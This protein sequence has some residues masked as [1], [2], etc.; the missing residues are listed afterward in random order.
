M[1]LRTTSV[2]AAVSSAVLG[3]PALS[4]RD[5]AAMSGI[6][7]EQAAR[8]WQ[9]LGF[10]AVADDERLFTRRDVD[11]LRFVHG[12]F[13]KG[14]VDPE[15]LVQMARATGQSLARVANMHVLSAAAEIEA[16]VQSPDLSDSDAA[17]CVAAIA[18]Q[19]VASHEPFLGYIWRRHLLAA[20]SQTAATA[21]QKAGE[22]DGAVVG[23][24]DLVDFTAMSERLSERELAS[25]VDRFEAI[26][27]AEIPDRGG[28]VVKILG[29]EVMFHN[30]DAVAGARTALALS[31]ACAADS[32][33]PEVRVGLAL[34]PILAWEGDVYGKTVNLASRLVGAA[35]P[36]T[37]LVSEELALRITSAPDLIVR[38]IRP[39]K[40]KG[41]GRTRC[42]VLRGA[43]DRPQDD[44]RARR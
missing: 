8:L 32:V 20:I 39:V 40:L 28:R 42:W 3:K 4:A 21:S 25:I 12:M 16:A 44:A 13:E 2:R 36:G 17:D 26:A 1:T 22:E 34:G 31:Q 35:R 38:E 37:V 41:L 6:P 10:P 19:I 5:V 7:V 27:Y 33:L 23:F 29:D 24:A 18:E 15:V 11:V 14:S 30:G 9:A 43:D